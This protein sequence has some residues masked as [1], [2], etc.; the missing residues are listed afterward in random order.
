MLETC[1]FTQAFPTWSLA[2]IDTNVHAYLVAHRAK[3][4]LH[5]DLSIGYHHRHR[6]EEY[7]EVLREFLPSL[8]ARVHSDEV[9][10]VSLEPDYLAITREHEL[11]RAHALRVG[12]GKHLNAARWGRRATE[13]TPKKGTQFVGDIGTSNQVS[14][15]FHGKL[16]T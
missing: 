13:E 5:D 6:A 12:D 16:C 9:R 15:R 8:V 7:F 4:D 1:I 14:L 11:L 2:H 3:F 10:H